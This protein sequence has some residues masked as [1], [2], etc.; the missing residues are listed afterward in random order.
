MYL[1]AL[2]LD[3]SSAEKSHFSGHYFK[4]KNPID[5]L[6]LI[7]RIG[8][9]WNLLQTEYYIILLFAFFLSNELFGE[10]KVIKDQL[11]MWTFIFDTLR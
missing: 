4:R 6:I 10:W 7:A 1:S 3:N 2:I 8:V 5:N 11:K 9:G